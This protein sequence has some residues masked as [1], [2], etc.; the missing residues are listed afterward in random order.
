MYFSNYYYFNK[1]V[2]LIIHQITIA[3]IKGSLDIVKIILIQRKMKVCLVRIK[4][5]KLP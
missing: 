5:K 1:I 2:H 4:L 3:K